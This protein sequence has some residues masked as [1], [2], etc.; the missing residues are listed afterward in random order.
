MG[1]MWERDLKVCHSVVFQTSNLVLLLTTKAEM[2]G[3]KSIEGMSTNQAP[4]TW[5]RIRGPPR[6]QISQGKVIFN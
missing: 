4:Q 6:A 5:E 3:T 1:R 2:Y